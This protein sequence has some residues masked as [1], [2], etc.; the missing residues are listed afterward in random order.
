MIHG[1]GKV[2]AGHTNDINY[3]LMVSVRP[4]AKIIFVSCSH[5]YL[6]ALFDEN[7]STEHS[8]FFFIM[9]FFRK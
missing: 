7:V 9:V 8:I 2:K 5:A 3:S 6:E 4:L 1:F